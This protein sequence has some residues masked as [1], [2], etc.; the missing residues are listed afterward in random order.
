MYLKGDHYTGVNYKLIGQIIQKRRRELEYTQSQLANMA[1]CSVT[2]LCR[3]E[4]GRGISLELLSRICYMLELS[5]DEVLGISAD[6]DPLVRQVGELLSPRSRD[7]Q[8][9]CFHLI[10]TILNFLKMMENTKGYRPFMGHTS[11]FSYAAAFSS[12]LASEEPGT[13]RDILLAQ[14]PWSETSLEAPVPYDKAFPRGSSDVGKTEILLEENA[15]FPEL[16]LPGMDRLSSLRNEPGYA[17]EKTH[18]EEVRG[19]EV[20]SPE[21]PGEEE[22]NTLEDDREEAETEHPV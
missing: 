4:S 16:P 22:E 5:M 17:E 14:S 15:L 19:S 21:T 12:L 10:G 9:L 1:D 20:S 18:A 8:Q 13:F 2:H 7:E 6:R 11:G 3:I